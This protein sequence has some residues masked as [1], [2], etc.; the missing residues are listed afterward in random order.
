MHVFLDT[1]ILY[2]KFKLDN[3]VISGLKTYL[4]LTKS[5][6][7]L[8][9][10]SFKEIV[11]KYKENLSDLKIEV[12]ERDFNNLNY[13]KKYDFTGLNE[14]IEKLGDEYES[15]LKSQLKWW[16]DIVKIDESFMEECVDRA[17]CK[18]PPC[19]KKEEFRDTVI[20]LTYA[21]MIN[22]GSKP[23]AFIS[24]NTKDFWEEL[25]PILL[26]DI[27]K[28]KRWKVVYRNSL[29]KFLEEYY[30]SVKWI[31]DYNYIQENLL[32]EEFCLELFDNE[33]DN[34]ELDA[35]GWDFEYNRTN[36]VGFIDLYELYIKEKF[37]IKWKECYI[38]SVTIEYETEFEAIDWW[39]YVTT[40]TPLEYLQVDLLFNKSDNSI[41]FNGISDHYFSHI[42]RN[43]ILKEMEA[44]AYYDF[45]KEREREERDKD[46]MDYC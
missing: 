12:L 2:G 41:S 27:E 5:K 26:N 42:D 14:K 24:N 31:V 23:I 30:E 13:Q 15:F 45:Y 39:H 46:F 21:K 25:N 3:S 32:T 34:I 19:G 8:S 37:K 6:A 9:E 22:E 18:R 4:Q 44:D 17:V 1:N 16:C 38:I 11:F 40:I 33:K 43:D 10:V 20:W 35:L 36:Y 28:G 29:E 7:Y